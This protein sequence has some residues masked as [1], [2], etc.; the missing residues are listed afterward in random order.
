M[1]RT[2]WTGP[3]LLAV[4]AFGWLPA[5]EADPL[6]ADTLRAA[7][8]TADQDEVA[9]LTYVATMI[10]QGWVPNDLA[11]STL[12]WARRKETPK[13]FQY[14]KYA[15][16]SR[17]AAIGITLP[18]DTPSLTST[19]RG[20]VF[21]HLLVKDIPAPNVTIRLEGTKYETA[22]TAKGEFVFRDV[23]YGTYT[24]R[25]IGGVTTLSRTAT[26]KIMLPSAPPSFDPVFVSLRLK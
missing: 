2:S 1:L 7:L 25:A 10:E 21:F 6:D 19:I 15:M 12:L 17:A 20:R 14:F 22:S 23:P 26:A 11:Q 4:L 18:L 13:R 9:Y 8:R 3:I 24:I 5:V 16:I